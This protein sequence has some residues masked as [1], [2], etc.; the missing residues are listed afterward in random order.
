MD[1]KEAVKFIAYLVTSA[2]GCIE[3]PKI[4]GSFRLVDSAGKFYGALKKHGLIDDRD[5]DEIISMIDEK[6][7]SCMFDEQE[8]IGMLDR[9]VDRLVDVTVSMEKS[10]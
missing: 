3:E 2:R 7:Y 8:F 6:K 9:V 5:I 10:E 4:Y 1:K